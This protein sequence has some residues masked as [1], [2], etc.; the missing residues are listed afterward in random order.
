MKINPINSTTINNTKKV[1]R[2]ISNYCN[3][4]K[5]CICDDILY[6]TKGVNDAYYMILT[7]ESHRKGDGTKAIK[8]V[9]K[10]SLANPKT[11]GRVLLHAQTIDGKTYPSGFYYKLGFRFVDDLKNNI[12]EQCL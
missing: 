1:I 3:N 5:M 8:K 10:K 11:Q 6:D 9:V 12:L 4:D 2:R 7:L